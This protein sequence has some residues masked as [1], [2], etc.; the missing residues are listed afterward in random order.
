MQEA[1]AYAKHKNLK[2]AAAELGM[3]WHT[4]YSRLR[5]AGVPVTGDKARYGTSRDRLA[6][7]AEQEFHRLVPEAEAM[8]EQQFQA[9]FD[10]LIHGHKVDV[11]ASLPRRLNKRF[12]AKSWAFSF[13]KQTLVCD[14][15]CCFCMGEE[16]QVERVLLVPSEFFAGIQTVSVSCAGKSKWH[17]YDIKPEALAEFFASMKGV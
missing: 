11:K 4:L 8:N 16:K 5:N 12:D 1:I 13:K 7:L 14:Y 2:L 10:F 17:D 3:T 15:M 9:K 6:V